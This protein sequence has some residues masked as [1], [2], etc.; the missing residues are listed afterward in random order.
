MEHVDRNNILKGDAFK[1]Y[2]NDDDFPYALKNLPDPPKQLY[3]IGNIDALSE[4]LAVVGARKAT[5]YGISCAKH[6]ASLAA[7][8]GI[9]IISGGAYGCDSASHKAAL[10]ENKQTVECKI[11]HKGLHALPLQFQCLL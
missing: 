2:P 11:F 9:T 10:K 1:I 6:F 4:G 8:E 3:V 7:K 5:P